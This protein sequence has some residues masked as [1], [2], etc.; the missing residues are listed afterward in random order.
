MQ[1]SVVS[2]LWASLPSSWHYYKHWEGGTLVHDMSPVP[3]HGSVQAHWPIRG[4]GRGQQP[5]RSGPHMTT[6]T[7]SLSSQL[8]TL[9]PLYSN[10]VF[11]CKEAGNMKLYL[12]LTG[13]EKSVDETMIQQSLTQCNSCQSGCKHC[14]KVYKVHKVYI[15]CLNH[16]SILLILRN[17]ICFI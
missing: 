8:L 7:L 5:M 6:C 2:Y 1:P 15:S 12:W 16:T 3:P 4:L 17:I 13:E 14:H 11:A 9:E 10:W